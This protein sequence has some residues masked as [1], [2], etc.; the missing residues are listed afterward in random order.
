MPDNRSKARG[1]AAYAK[2]DA[3]V[4]RSPS[5]PLPPLWHSIPGALWLLNGKVPSLWTYTRLLLLLGLVSIAAGLLMGFIG[6]IIVWVVFKENGTSVALTM[7]ISTFTFGTTAAVF[8]VG[9]GLL[10]YLAAV[11]DRESGEL[12]VEAAEQDDLPEDT[13]P[14]VATGIVPKMDL[15]DYEDHKNDDT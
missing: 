1:E 12:A 15:G 9:S 3:A 10:A 13:P 4:G 11:N 2:V 14:R 6:A 8:L 7:L 5:R